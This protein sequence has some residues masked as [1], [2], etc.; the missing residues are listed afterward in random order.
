MKT[1]I[2]NASLMLSVSL[3][4]TA[5]ASDFRDEIAAYESCIQKIERDWQ[6]EGRHVFDKRYGRNRD[7]SDHNYVF[8]INSKVL[9]M[10]TGKTQELRSRCE[11]E[12][13]GMV[14]RLQT[15]SGQW[16]L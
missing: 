13:F 2:M 16:D 11:S 1:L 6:G 3:V 14:Q 8:W 7:K 15:E 4:A 12:G 5:Q 9:D 10:D